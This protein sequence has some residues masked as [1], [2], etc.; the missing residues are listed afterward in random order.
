MYRLVSCLIVRVMPECPGQIGTRCEK[1][2]IRC[3]DRG[4][5]AMLDLW[6]EKGRK[7]K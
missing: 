1:D 7:S 3:L 4:N 6:H 5:F 2:G